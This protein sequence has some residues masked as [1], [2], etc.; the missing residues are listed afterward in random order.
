[1]LDS[2]MLRNCS[3]LEPKTALMKNPDHYKPSINMES[4]L[5]Y[6]GFK[7]SWF[8]MCC[9]DSRQFTSIKTLI[10]EILIINPKFLQKWIPALKKKVKQILINFAKLYVNQ[11]QV[12]GVLKMP[13]SCLTGQANV[14]ICIA[15]IGIVYSEY[16]NFVLAIKPSQVLQNVKNPFKCKFRTYSYWWA[17]KVTWLQ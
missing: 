4:T 15:L 2:F 13:N 16:N 8:L 6:W 14:V 7:L 10:T 17:N 12:N 9:K 1:M 3:P 5:T 11:V